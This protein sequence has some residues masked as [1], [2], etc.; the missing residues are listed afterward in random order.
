MDFEVRC[1]SCGHV[2]AKERD[3][4][5][6]AAMYMTVHFG[7]DTKCN[8]CGEVGISAYAGNREQNEWHKIKPEG[9]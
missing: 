3:E 4:R 5:F 9:E 7:F 8:K 2:Y 6:D 1:D